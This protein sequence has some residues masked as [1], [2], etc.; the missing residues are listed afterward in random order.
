[1]K[2]EVID[3]I[4]SVLPLYIVEKNS[5]PLRVENTDIQKKIE[6]ENQQ[7]TYKE[8]YIENGELKK[9]ETCFD[10]AKKTI[11]VNR[12]ER[13]S[14]YRNKCIKEK[15][16]ICEICG[17]DFSIYGE[18]GKG[19]I[20]AHHCTPLYKIGHEIEIS[21]D[22]LVPVCSNCHS[23]LHRYRDEMTVEELK[24]IVHNNKS[25]LKQ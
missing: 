16:A 21:L 11:I 13:D 10:G 12:Y 9:G 14:K 7:N 2:I 1:M 25:R 8:D 24:E 3:N 23:I 4:E 17:C 5:K 22:D 6:I 18:R 19:F 15:G 20:E